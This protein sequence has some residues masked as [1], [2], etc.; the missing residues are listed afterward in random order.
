[1]G[2]VNHCAGVKLALDETK[3]GVVVEKGKKTCHRLD[4]ELVNSIN[5]ENKELHKTAA[6][7]VRR[8]N[9]EP[10]DKCRPLLGLYT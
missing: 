9:Y 5:A 8:Y 10:C 6:L 2:I 1:L 7:A 4:C 3:V